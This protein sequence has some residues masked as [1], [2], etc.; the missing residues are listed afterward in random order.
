MNDSNVWRIEGLVITVKIY[1]NTR[2]RHGFCANGVTWQLL[3]HIRR[4]RGTSMHLSFEKVNELEQP[5]EE[6]SAACTLIM[7]AN[8]LLLP[9]GWL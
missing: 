7:Q 2:S 6:S 9:P 5:G 4:R 1:F 3:I 8:V